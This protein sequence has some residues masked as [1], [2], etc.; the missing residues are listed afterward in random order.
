MRCSLPGRLELPTLR[1]T[2][3]R[4]NQLSYGS[5]ALVRAGTHTHSLHDTRS[6]RRRNGSGSREENAKHARVR[7][8]SCAFVCVRVRPC[9]FVCVCVTCVCMYVYLYVCTFDILPG[10]SGLVAEYIVAIDVTRVRSP[11]DANLRG[12]PNSWLFWCAKVLAVICHRCHLGAV[13][14]RCEPTG[15]FLDR[16]F[17]GLRN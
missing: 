1:L 2:A 14:E 9:A 5:T 7:V 4:S 15:C 10:I 13:P 3:S 17:L 8:C 11:A 6:W 16:D 12:V